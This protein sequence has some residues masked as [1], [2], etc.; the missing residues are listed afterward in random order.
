M[1]IILKKGNFSPP[2]SGCFE[3]QPPSFCGCTRAQRAAPSRAAGGK[4]HALACNF[5]DDEDGCSRRRR[6]A[7]RC[8]SQKNAPNVRRMKWSLAHSFAA[9]QRLGLVWSRRGGSP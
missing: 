8:P 9:K 1:G 5:R 3:E 6:V 2:F 7:R 4:K